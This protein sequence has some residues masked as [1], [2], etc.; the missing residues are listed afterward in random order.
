MTE[1]TNNV[2]HDAV[3]NFAGR[4]EAANQTSTAGLVEL[5]GQRD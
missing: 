5:A 3:R 1:T 4:I 2:D